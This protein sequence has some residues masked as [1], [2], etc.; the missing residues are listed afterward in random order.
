MSHTL[1][2]R[3]QNGRRNT[4]REWR[5]VPHPAFLLSCESPKL[6]FHPVVKQGCLDL[7]HP[8]TTCYTSP[9]C[10]GHMRQYMA[11]TLH[12]IKF[13]QKLCSGNNV[14]LLGLWCNF[15]GINTFFRPVWAPG[16]H[17]VHIPYLENHS[18]TQAIVQK[19]NAG[20]TI[21]HT[22]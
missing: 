22:R 19:Y 15:Q 1:G 14:L 16:L 2:R 11:S 5:S 18:K 12:H 13:Y 3:T 4:R 8:W 20:K 7:C 6:H 10:E 17:A 9:Y 21:I